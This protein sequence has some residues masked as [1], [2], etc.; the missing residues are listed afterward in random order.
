MDE[1]RDR[2]NDPDEQEPEIARHWS[3]RI[4]SLLILLIVLVAIGFVIVQYM[5]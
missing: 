4:E 1:R 3:R 5:I 2:Y